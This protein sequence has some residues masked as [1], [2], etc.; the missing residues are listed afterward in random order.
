MDPEM[1]KKR[2]NERDKEAKKRKRTEQKRQ[3]MAEAR[4]LKG[5]IRATVRRNIG[6]AKGPLV[7]LVNKLIR[8]KLRTR[9]KNI[10]ENVRYLIPTMFI[11][12]GCGL[13]DDPSFQEITEHLIVEIQVNIGPQG[14]PKWID[15]LL[16]KKS[17]IDGAGF[18]LFANTDFEAFTSLGIFSGSKEKFRDT[19]CSKY[20]IQVNRDGEK[21]YFIDANGSKGHEIFFGLHLANDPYYGLDEERQLGTGKKLEPNFEVYESMEAM[22]MKAIKKGTEL[23]LDYR[24]GQE[25][26]NDS[27]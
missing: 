4:R 21:P 24:T 22:T 5:R 27:I 8:M 16:I 13:T 19:E 15:W 7:N 26:R 1:K 6:D 25:E 14:R 2:K 17:N 3:L 12:D 9:N 23:L 20:A 10:R 18:G 11:T